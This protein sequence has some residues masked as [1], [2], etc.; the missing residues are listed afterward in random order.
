MADPIADDPVIVEPNAIKADM[1][2]IIFYVPQS[3]IPKNKIKYK[4]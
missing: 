1:N 3:L 4:S 2:F